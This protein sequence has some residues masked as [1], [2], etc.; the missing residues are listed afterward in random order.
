MS[1]GIMYDYD[2]EC[3]LKKTPTSPTLHINNNNMFS[4]HAN[5]VTSSSAQ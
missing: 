5:T 3:G 1:R 2:Y 4:L